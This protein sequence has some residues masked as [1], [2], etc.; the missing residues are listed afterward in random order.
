MIIDTNEIEDLIKTMT[1][2]DM[3]SI[4][5]EKSTLEQLQVDKERLYRSDLNTLIKLQNAVN[6]FKYKE[7]EAFEKERRAI[8]KQKEAERVHANYIGI[9]VGQTRIITASDYTMNH[10]IVLESEAIKKRINKYKNFFKQEEAKKSSTTRKDYIRSFKKHIKNI[11]KSNFIPQ[12]EKMY[13]QPTIYV[14]GKHFLVPSKY[15]VQVIL[16]E[17]VFEILQD[18]SNDSKSIVGVRYVNDRY[19]SV[20]C[21]ECNKGNSL[22]KTKG[23][24]FCVNCYFHHEN[25]DVVACHNILRNYE[26]IREEKYKL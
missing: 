8:A 1:D 23:G 19:T 16:T 6:R 11:I 15:S 17:C 5:L 10:Y 12:L 25:N 24:F 13:K 14:I 20:T 22:N 21:P 3:L 4:E 2:D 18:M 26:S 9:D 7:K